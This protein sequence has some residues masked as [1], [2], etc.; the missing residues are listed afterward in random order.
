MAEFRIKLIVIIK[1][2]V[3]IFSIPI[4]LARQASY[5]LVTSCSNR[6]IQS[7]GSN[8][9][10]YI[11]QGIPGKSGKCAIV[12]IQTIDPTGWFSQ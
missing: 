2:P 3:V 6:I 11:S 12:V 5:A 10:I 9:G 8:E 7:M 1:P 4:W